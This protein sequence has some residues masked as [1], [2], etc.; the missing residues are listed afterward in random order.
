MRS[1]VR[2][3]LLTCRGAGRPALKCFYRSL[4]SRCVAEINRMKERHV[5]R[6]LESFELMMACR[7]EAE[8]FK[9]LQEA[10]RT[11]SS[12]LACSRK[13]PLTKVSLETMAV[14]YGEL[15]FW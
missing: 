14:H 4:Q 15:F 5:A 2:H 8:A 13:E 3:A 10:L 6:E 1:K 12:K 11:C 9:T 7:R